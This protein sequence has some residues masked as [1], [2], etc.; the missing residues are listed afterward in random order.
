MGIKFKR[1][2]L[3]FLL[4]LGIFLLEIV[5]WLKYKPDFSKPAPASGIFILVMVLGI[6]LTI[7]IYRKWTA[8]PPRCSLFYGPV[9]FESYD[10]RGNFV[11]VKTRNEACGDKSVGRV[12]VYGDSR[13]NTEH[14]CRGHDPEIGWMKTWLKNQGLEICPGTVKRFPVT[15]DGKDDDGPDLT[16][17]FP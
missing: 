7:N 11:G 9:D 14:F 8:P 16:P 15:G 6:L 13:R 10:F 5:A 4:I 12:Q 1:P 17:R 2:P 3:P